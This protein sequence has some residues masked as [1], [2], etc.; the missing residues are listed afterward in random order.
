ME[1]RPVRKTSASGAVF[2]QLIAE[3][4]AGGLEP[5]E[6][7]PA[8]RA[9]TESLSV[10]RG[11]VREALQRLAQ[12]GLV[13]INHGEPTRALDYRQSAGLDLLGRLLFDRD[14]RLDIE[15]ARSITE[16]RAAIGP[17]I[18]RLAALRCR[19]DMIP[20][21]E[22]IVDAMANA[23]GDLERLARID[24]DFWDVLT[25]AADN[26]AYRLAFNSLRQTYE[27]MAGELTGVMAAELTDLDARR[28]IV[29]ALHASDASA[30]ESAARSLLARGSLAITEALAA[31]EGGER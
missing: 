6:S 24:L 9:L 15:V 21:F 5:G 22:S 10:N 29:A 7:L 11:A 23:G 2:E 13:E 12:A 14:G 28:A 27:P 4:V 20:V 16:M 17:D 19:A 25:D 8:E 26:I 30:A 18:A 1:L 3:L 31:L